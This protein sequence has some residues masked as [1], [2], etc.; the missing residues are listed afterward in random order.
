ML[1]RTR[2]RWLIISLIGVA[3]VINYIDRSSLAVMWPAMSRETHL[4]KE[5]YATIIS[6]F[7]VAYAFGQAFSGRFFDR[8]GTRIGFV[9]TI[10]VWSTAAALHGL[11]RS[12]SGL[13]MA[14]G[15]LGFSEAGNWPGAT[16][17]VAEWFPRHE[18][19][20]AQGIFNAG[21]SLGAVV[22]APAIALLYL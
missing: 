2:L 18:R 1:L 9:C 11:V 14:R 7:M 20:L 8:V 17:A 10:A 16:K 3:T 6:V 12:M 13:L 22:S 19:A 15:L 5:A 21:A 4:S